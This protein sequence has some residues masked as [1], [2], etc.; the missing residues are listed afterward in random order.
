MCIYHK[1]KQ[2]NENIK[3]KVEGRLSHLNKL[4]TY[5]QV[6]QSKVTEEKKGNANNYET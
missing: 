5:Y 1:T 6:T 2:H 4:F 3:V